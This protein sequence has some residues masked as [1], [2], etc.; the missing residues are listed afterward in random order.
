MDTLSVWLSPLVFPLFWTGGGG[1]NSGGSQICAAGDFFVDLTC[2]SLGKHSSKM[3]IE[4]EN[5]QCLPC[6]IRNDVGIDG[7]AT[8]K[9]KPK[10]E[11]WVGACI[12][13]PHTHLINATLQLC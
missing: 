8:F 6:V 2:F 5:E 12:N 13:M 3:Q 10:Q 11:D 7:K 4:G 9:G 1:I